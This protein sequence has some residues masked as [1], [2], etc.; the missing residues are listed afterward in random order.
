MPR[1]LTLRQFASSRTYCGLDPSPLMAAVYDASEGIRPTTIDDATC[2]VHF[3]CELDALPTAPRRTVAVRAGGRGGKS[4]RLMA[5]A[6]LHRAWT[7]PLPTLRRGEVASSMLVAPD[8]SL[9]RQ[10]LSF[11]HGYVE[12]S[13]LLRRALIDEPTKDSIELRRPDGK[14]VR[15]EV[16]AASRGGRGVRGRTLCFAGLDEACFFFDELSGVVN[17]ADLYRA[18]AQ[19]VVPGGQV[20]IAST[21]WIA[22]TGLLETLIAK[23][24]G[25][26]D[27][28]L[29]LTAGT[30]ALN[31]TW[32]P[33]GEIER[34]LREQD[35]D[36]AVREIDG[37]PMSGGAGTFFDGSALT[38]CVDE[39]LVLPMSASLCRRAAFGGDIGLV[40]DS[41][42]LVGVADVGR[43]LTVIA[44]SEL[45]PTKGNPLRPKAV[46]DDFA[47]TMTRFGARSFMADAHYRESV[48]E[49][50]APHGIRFAD[51]PGGRDGKS[52]VFLHAKKL[53]HEGR[54]RIPNHPRLLTQ[55]RQ[56]VSRPAPG[57]GL[58]ITSPRR[59]GGGGHGDIASAFV[60]ALWAGRTAL[61]KPITFHG[62]CAVRNSDAD[63]F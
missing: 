5:V 48:R 54:V 63:G 49:H 56:V 32:D 19:R 31:P 57:G 38:A 23:N 62:I 27:H 20:W 33:T 39:T 25:T 18:T 29:V 45:R 4:S 9:A 37:Q 40:S 16:R 50:L 51:A 44:V 12:D 28:A 17:D 24:F 3:G 2:L 6:A 15:V 14:R 43:T 60:L 11:V 41:S 34:D 59:R 1:V 61:K 53:I 22:D 36:A 26:H 8:M 7:V 10:T 58:A 46:I 47:A 35:P 42:A 13:A 55:L 30:R 21:P 52:D